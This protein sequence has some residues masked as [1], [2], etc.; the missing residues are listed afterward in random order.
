MSK[1]KLEKIPYSTDRNKTKT[2]KKTPKTKTQNP[3]LLRKDEHIQNKNIFESQGVSYG[4]N[5]LRFTPQY[6]ND[7]LKRQKAL[8]TLWG[9]MEDLQ[10]GNLVLMLRKRGKRWKEDNRELSIILFNLNSQKNQKLT[11]FKNTA[12]T[13]KTNN[14]QK[15]SLSNDL[16]HFLQWEGNSHCGWEASS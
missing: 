15:E 9:S 14:S 7:W 11:Y 1:F 2:N 4:L 3:L 8:E 10:M 6:L 13:N 5:I 12:K 16:S